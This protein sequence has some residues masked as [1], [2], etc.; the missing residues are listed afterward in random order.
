MVPDPMLLSQKIHLVL[1]I[2]TCL[3]ILTGSLAETCGQAPGERVVVTANVETKIY[4][5]NVDKVY[6]GDIHTVIAVNG[7]W[8]ALN[9]VKGWLPSR[10]VISL[11]SAMQLYEKRIQDNENDSDAFAF[12]GMLFYEIDDYAK[13]DADFTQSLRLNPKNAAT[14]SNRGMVRKL[15]QDYAQALADF[16]QALT[17]NP[18][19]AGAYYNR[20]LVQFELGQFEESID[21]YDQADKHQPNDP[22]TLINRGFAKQSLGNRGS[23]END[24]LAA[25]ELDGN[26]SESYIGMSN[27]K[28]DENDLPAAL[29][30]A[31]LSVEKHPRNG[32]ALNSR[33]WVKFKMGEL[34]DAMQ[35]FDL[36]IRYAP[37]QSIIYNNRGVCYAEQEKYQQAIGNYSRAIKL[38]PRSAVAYSN[39]GTA[40]MGTSQF[41]RAQ[42]DF[43]KAI[44]Y[45]PRL[46]D[47]VNGYAWFLA[48]CPSDKYRD[49]DKA[50]ELANSACELSDWKDW[51]HLDTLAAAYA[52]KGDFE[53]AVNM[54]ERAAKLAPD[55]VQDSCRDRIALYRS[56]K[57][58]RSNQGKPSLGSS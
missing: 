56:G 22:W 19:Y 7:A 24:F 52:E 15:M 55:S 36:A 53:K 12:R 21:S 29:K 20:G 8:C 26:L 14:W 31:N 41:D 48:T 37:Q 58:L 47:A 57:P 54:A 42:Q 11:K 1:P 34:S 40:Y 2:V 3:A 45:A 32:M 27:L 13:A 25:I 17:I 50:T 23:A 9:R 44:E 10:Y 39:R 30:Y 33:G 4:K 18:E 28:L 35:D 16:D 5:E 49:G 46:T 43:E 6:T 51:S 38:F